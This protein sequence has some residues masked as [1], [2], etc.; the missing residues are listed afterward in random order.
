[1]KLLMTN[2]FD[3]IYKVFSPFNFKSR[4]NKKK[5]KIG[6]AVLISDRPDYLEISLNSLFK[7]KID[8]LDVT[9]LLFDNGKL[10]KRKE[11]IINKKRNRKYK[12]IRKSGNNKSKSWGE[13]F[14]KAIKILLNYDDFDI[15][16]SCDSDVIYHE[17]WLLK[18][19]ENF[20]WIKNNHK[21]H[22]LGP[23]S[24][25]NS[26]D[27]PFHQVL[28]EFSA[29]SGEKYL[30]K[31]RMGALNYF[32]LT[33]D[34]KKIGFFEE[35]KD[36]ETIMTKK[37]SKY[38]IRNVSL[39]TSYVDHIGAISEL[40]KTRKVK[41]GEINYVYGMDY[42]KGNWNFKK[43]LFKNEKIDLVIPY[44][45]KDIE[46]INL[47][48]ENAKKYL[49][50]KNIFVITSLENID[51]IKHKV[52]II[53]EKT[54]LKNINLKKLKKIWNL[55]TNGK[56]LDV[57]PGW[58]FQQIIKLEISRKVK[59]I[60]KY[61]LI[62]DSDTIFLR[63]VHF[64]DRNKPLLN[65]GNKIHKPYFKMT[66]K[67]LGLDKETKTSYISHHMIVNKNLVKIM[68]DEIEKYTNEKYWYMAL[69]K[70]YDYKIHSG[71]SEYETYGLFLEK[72]YYNSY[73][74]RPLQNIDINYIPNDMEQKKLAK[75]Y[76]YV[77]SHQYS[78]KS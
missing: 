2:F 70:L 57:T 64:F 6:I 69:L 3:Y 47:C 29:K 1:M 11:L 33:R 4:I 25:F 35:N 65:V 23:F 34:L 41:L 62:L 7:S 78:R 15:V 5:L 71:F 61:Y 26:S 43:N 31:K 9:F 53:N 42:A 14:N 46:T 27:Q 39:K 74:I 51:D 49:D 66:K 45:K 20:V 59:N 12:I 8:N 50:I 76:D 37:F 32:W 55:K 60:S 24:S 73:K 56:H 17:D 22:I 68:L 67:L 36:D 52:K 21:K 63:R 18:T 44:H 38:R 13:A 75:K 48:I 58:V 10:D 40:D 72:K 54:F 30:I 77:S 16:A 28:G 19:I